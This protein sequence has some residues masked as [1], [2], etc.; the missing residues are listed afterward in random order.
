MSY[1]L[2]P[3]PAPPAKNQTLFGTALA[4]MAMLMFIG[5]LIGLYLSVRRDVKTPETPWVP[6]SSPFAEVPANVMLITVL[7]IPLFAVWAWRAAKRHQRAFTGLALGVVAL[8]A[9]AAINAQMY[10]YT[11]MDITTEGS[12]FATMFWTVTGAMVVV[13]VIGVLF[14]LVAAFRSLGGRR[15]EGVLTSLALYWFVAAVAVSAV[16]YAVYVTK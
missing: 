2:P 3:A 13:L 9:L 4:S 12:P 1:A 8:F 7:A 11:Q 5:G 16:W 10:L 14:T 15:D 6:E